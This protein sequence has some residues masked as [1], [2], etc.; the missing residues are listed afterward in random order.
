[1]MPEPSDAA[2][3]FPASCD[4]CPHRERVAGNCTRDEAWDLAR[5]FLR[6]P[7]APCPVRTEAFET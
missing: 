1:M 7:D 5:Y 3:L 6:H 2:A 4:G